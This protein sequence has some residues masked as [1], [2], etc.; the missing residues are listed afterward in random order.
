MI[1]TATVAL[2]SRRTIG[3]IPSTTSLSSR[4]SGF[5]GCFRAKVRSWRVRAAA[6][7]V[8]SRISSTLARRSSPGWRSRLR[9]SA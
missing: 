8:A 1:V 7:S 5:D 4:T 2:T 9:S 6:R 3:A